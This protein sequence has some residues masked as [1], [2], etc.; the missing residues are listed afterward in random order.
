[1]VY[2]HIERTIMVLNS[3]IRDVCFDRVLTDKELEALALIAQAK[4]LLEAARS[5]L[6]QIDADA[7]KFSIQANQLEKDGT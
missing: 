2:S 3:V 7:A 5:R 1:M 4:V 6:D